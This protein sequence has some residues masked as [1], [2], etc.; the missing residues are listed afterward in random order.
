MPSYT[1]FFAV[2]PVWLILA[3]LHVVTFT[4]LLIIYGL[5]VTCDML[6][7]GYCAIKNER[8]WLMLLFP[9][10]EII[11]VPYILGVS[12]RGFFG[13]FE[14][15]GRQTGAVNIEYGNNPHD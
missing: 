15:H 2:M 8:P 13:T 12:V 7:T 3:S 14:W 6:L 4:P 10:A 9:F 11:H 1:A 5:K